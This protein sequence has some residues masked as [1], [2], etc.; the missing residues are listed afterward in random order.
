M[1][2]KDGRRSNKRYFSRSTEE[3]LFEWGLT[4]FKVAVGDAQ[5]VKNRSKRLRVLW[6]C[7]GLPVVVEHRNTVCE[8]L[9]LL[10]LRCERDCSAARRGVLSQ[11]GG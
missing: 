9:D 4:E 2:V 8:D 11:A 7:C 1:A 5:H 10:G 6:V 3:K